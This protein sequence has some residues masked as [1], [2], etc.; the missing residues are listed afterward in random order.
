MCTIE[1]HTKEQQRNPEV[2]VIILQGEKLTQVNGEPKICPSTSFLGVAVRVKIDGLSGVKLTEVQS[3]TQVSYDVKA[4]MEERERRSGLVVVG[5]ALN[6]G[7]RPSVAKFEVKGVATLEG[8]DE[9]VKKML[10]PDPETQIPLLFQS[11][12]QHSF[13]SMYLLA[14]LINCPYPPPNLLRSPQQESPTLQMDTSVSAP[15]TDLVEHDEQV[16]NPEDEMTSPTSPMTAVQGEKVTAS[17][18]GANTGSQ[19]GQ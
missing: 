18:Q 9:N 14:T 16:P 7:T 3:G 17:E 2:I 13:M 19:T 11:V 4:R 5:F 10:E 12:Y 6:V 8:K 1:L 15:E